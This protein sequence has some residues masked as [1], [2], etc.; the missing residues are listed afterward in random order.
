MVAHYEEFYKV[1]TSCAQGNIF[2]VLSPPWNSPLEDAFVWIGGWRPSS[3]FQ[4]LYSV[5]GLQLES[6]LD[7]LLRGATTGDLSYL[8]SEQLIRIDALHRKTIQEERAITEE[9]AKQQDKVADA[10][11]VQLSHD[12]S[13]STGVEG[14]ANNST[15][16]DRV[17]SIMKPR[18]EGFHKVLEAADDLRIRT[19]KG[20]VDILSPRQAI[21]FL[22]SAAEL[23]LRLHDWGKQKEERQIAALLQHPTAAQAG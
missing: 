21:H 7:G 14:A 18:E 16:D 17:D 20:V 13:R 5:A 23:Q 15:D 9:I 1:K 11:M 6:R 3:A 22:I 8:S 4:L 10:E 2:P 19:L 12:M